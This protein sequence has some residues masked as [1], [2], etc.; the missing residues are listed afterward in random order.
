MKLSLLTS[1]LLLISIS[2]YADT[3][4]NSDFQDYAKSVIA[5]YNDYSDDQV[6]EVSL[7]NDNATIVDNSQNEIYY[8]TW[9]LLKVKE[10]SGA[11]QQLVLPIRGYTE[12]VD[13]DFG[14]SVYGPC[15][16]DRDGPGYFKAQRIK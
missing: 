13:S 12:K 16:I 8:E 6:L 9:A 10:K 1:L 5:K 2:G 3:C 4:H 15:V 14:K 7:V 11:I